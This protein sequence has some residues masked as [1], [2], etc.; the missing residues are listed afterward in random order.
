MRVEIQDDGGART[1][2][3]IP[4][5]REGSAECGRGLMVVDGLAD[6]WGS[7]TGVAGRTTVWFEVTG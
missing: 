3:M 2:P 4:E 6:G 7:F 1:R 5:Q